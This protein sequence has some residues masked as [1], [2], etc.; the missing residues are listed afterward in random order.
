[1]QPLIRLSLWLILAV[2]VSAAPTSL[3]GRADPLPPSQD[4]FY[5]A[6]A[7]YESAAPGTILKSRTIPSPFAFEGKDPL[8]IKQAYQLL[9]RTTDTQGNPEAALTTVL[10][11][12][13]ADS[14]KLVSY[15]TAEDAAFV[16]CAPSYTFQHGSTDSQSIEEFL[17]LAALDHG[18][19]VSSPDYEGLQAAFV[20]GTQAD[21]AV[22]DSIRAAK[23]STNVT[24]LPSSATTVVCKALPLCE[25]L[26]LSSKVVRGTSFQAVFRF[27]E[28]L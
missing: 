27:L 10:V 13:N 16:G 26:C 20:A 3:F 9:Y 11:P 21:H 8:R 15:Q 28:K 12:N 5:Q 6:P 18:Y 19:F 17:I 25:N 4:P 22:L 24:G 14:T 23:A 1:M 2:A 7:G